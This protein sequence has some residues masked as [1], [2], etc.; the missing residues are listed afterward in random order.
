[1]TNPSLLLAGTSVTIIHI[2]KFP[3]KIKGTY[4]QNEELQFAS[5]IAKL[6]A[7]SAHANVKTHEGNV[8]VNEGMV[9]SCISHTPKFSTRILTTFRRIAICTANCKTH[10]TPDHHSIPKLPQLVKG[11]HQFTP[12][13]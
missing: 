11:N 9:N 8:I 4:L 3:R 5:Q 2:E 13:I 10:Q 12:Y 6:N 7:T 1:M